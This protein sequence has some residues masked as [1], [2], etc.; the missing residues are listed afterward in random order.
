MEE[1]NSKAAK[2]FVC[3]FVFGILVSALW[4]YTMWLNGAIA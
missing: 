4:L 2:M 1:D 3:G